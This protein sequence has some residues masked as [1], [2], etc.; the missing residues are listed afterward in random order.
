MSSIKC[1]ERALDILNLMYQNGGKMTLTE[2]SNEL[3]L[4]KSTV[5]R[6]LLTLTEKDFIQ[7]DELSGAY[8]LGSRVFMMG[9]VAARSIPV[10]KIAR[11]HL[12]YLSEKYDEYADLS[13]LDNGIH[14]NE[15]AAANNEFVVVFQQYQNTTYTKN[16][17]TPSQCESSDVFLPAVYLCFI[18]FNKNMNEIELDKHYMKINNRCPNKKWLF[19]EFKQAIEEIRVQGYSYLEGDIKKGYMCIAAPVFDKT[20]TLIAVLSMRGSKTKFSKLTLKNAISDIVNT[21]KIISDQCFLNQ[22]VKGEDEI[23]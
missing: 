5:H 15:S 20:N 18:A 3:S 12:S 8:T 2:I 14:G 1:L 17:I 22:V 16:L 21:A 9:L 13:I 19:D 23:E 7:R 10:S 4:Y 11:P 6:T